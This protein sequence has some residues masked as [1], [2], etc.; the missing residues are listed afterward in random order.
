MSA[1]LQK[2]REEARTIFEGRGIPTRRV[3]EWKY[4]DL[5]SALGEAGIGAAQAELRV[6]HLPAGVESFDLAQ[7]NPPDWVTAH[8][9]LANRNVKSAASLSLS[10]GGGAFSSPP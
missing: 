4:S 8:F 7:A 6:A 3:E 5:R 1:A 10:A 2:R 9:G